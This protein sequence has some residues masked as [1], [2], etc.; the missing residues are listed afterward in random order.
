MWSIKVLELLVT[1]VASETNCVRPK[2]TMYSVQTFL[3]GYLIDL[4]LYPPLG[5]FPCL[6]LINFLYSLQKLYSNG[7]LNLEVSK[8]C[9]PEKIYF[10]QVLFRAIN[11]QDFHVQGQFF[12]YSKFPLLHRL[13]VHPQSLFPC[14]F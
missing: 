14:L 2:N 3:F 1:L 5:K 7:P 9:Q 10:S 6:P 8:Y 4:C 11:T 12:W 13:I